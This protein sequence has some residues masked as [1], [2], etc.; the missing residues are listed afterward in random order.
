MFNKINMKILSIDDEK[1]NLMIVEGM[2]KELGISVDSFQDPVEAVAYASDNEP[3]LVIVDYLM[4]GMD[5]I[6]VIQ[7]I[8]NSYPEVPI[9]MITTVSGDKKLK[10]NALELGA[11]E[12]LNKPLDYAEFKARVL[13]LLRMRAYHLLL[14]DRTSLLEKEVRK[15]TDEILHR[16]HETIVIL[17]KVADFK[18]KE[19]GAHISRVS[20]YS[21]LLAE[22]IGENMDYQEL[23]FNSSPMHDIGKIGIPDKIIAKPGKLDSSE[24]IIM[25]THTIIG[26]NIL[27]ETNSDYLREGAVIALTHHEKFDGTGYPHGIKGDSIPLSG[28]ITAITDVFD[29]LRSKRPYKDPWEIDKI[30]DYMTKASSLHFDPQLI[31]AFFSKIEELEI[32]QSSFQEEAIPYNDIN[33]EV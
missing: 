9:V 28:R 1:T 33:F 13:N 29:A 17:G 23:I 8:R 31:K 22:L 32:I 10:L 12:F 14:Q 6:E 21:R 5:G 27:K 3:D 30:V 18:D 15:A 25:Q 11:T 2:C 24:K 7:Y 20:H 16:E 19:T 4:P 26:Y